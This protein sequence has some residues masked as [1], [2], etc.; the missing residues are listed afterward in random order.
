MAVTHLMIRLAPGDER[1][2][3]DLG[4]WYVRLGQLLVNSGRL[5]EG[6]DYLRRAEAIVSAG[7]K[8][9][10]ARDRDSERNADGGRHPMVAAETAATPPP[11][12][13]TGPFSFFVAQI[14]LV[15][16]LVQRVHFGDS[17]QPRVPTRML[18][19]FRLASRYTD[20]VP[21]RS[22]ATPLDRA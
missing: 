22:H 3:R 19:R 7:R 10:D 12:G 8:G 14:V 16:S 18:A 6:E 1:W 5:A 20:A 17:R 21:D 9:P 13:V 15:K 11:P 4:L 2:Q